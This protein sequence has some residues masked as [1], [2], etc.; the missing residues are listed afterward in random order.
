MAQEYLQEGPSYSDGKFYCP[1]AE[2]H[3]GW[4][5]NQKLVLST[6]NDLKEGQQQLKADIA[7]EI[8]NLKTEQKALDTRQ[9]CLEQQFARHETAMSIKVGLMWTIFGAVALAY[10][11]LVVKYLPALL[12]L[13]EK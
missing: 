5:E 1:W 10:I 12:A 4:L 11:G 3:K 7:E 2:S 6:L 13:L 9:H 8:K